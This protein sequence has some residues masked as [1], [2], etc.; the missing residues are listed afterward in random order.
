MDKEESKYQKR[1]LRLRTDFHTEGTGSHPREKCQELV[2]RPG[3]G[4]R[5]EEEV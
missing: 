2:V 5:F 3:W 4:V 1:G